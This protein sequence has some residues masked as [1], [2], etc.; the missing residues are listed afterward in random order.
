MHRITTLAAGLLALS[1]AAGAFAGESAIV[2]RLKQDGTIQVFKDRF[3]PKFPDGT[4]VASITAAPAEGGPRLKRASADGC[5]RRSRLV[6]GS[7]SP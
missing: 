5:R 2:G 7:L 4:P 3:Q 6:H 1:V